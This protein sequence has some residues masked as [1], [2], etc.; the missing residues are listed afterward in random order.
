MKQIIAKV[1]ERKTISPNPQ[2]L[3][4]IPFDSGINT[5]DYVKIEKTEVIEE[6]I[7]EAKRRI[8]MSKFQ[9][10]KEG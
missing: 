9:A 2:K 1:W 4:T 7:G 3:V 8:K 6:G 10:R 5:G